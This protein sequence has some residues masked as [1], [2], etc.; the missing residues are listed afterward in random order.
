MA[1]AEAAFDV[2][3]DPV[4]LPDYVPTLELVESIA[5]DGELDPD[6][7]LAERDGAPAAGFVADRATRRIAWGRPGDAYGGSIAVAEGT[8][9]TSGVTI[10]LRT[11]DDVDPDEVNRVLDQA[12]AGVR[13]VLLRR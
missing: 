12:V 10:R 11:R 13:R 4:R 3:S 5:I 7:E 2:L 6:E 8:A 1:G 9:S